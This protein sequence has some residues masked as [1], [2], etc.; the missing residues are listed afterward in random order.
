MP[1][2][3]TEA[4]DAMKTKRVAYGSLVAVLIKA[5][6]DLKADNDSLRAANNDEATQIRALTARLDA[7]EAERSVASK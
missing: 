6:Q 5:M 4:N 3:V 1:E 2:V 7:L